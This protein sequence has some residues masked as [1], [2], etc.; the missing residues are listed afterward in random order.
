MFVPVVPP[1]LGLLIGCELPVLMTAGGEIPGL[2]I[3]AGLLT[4]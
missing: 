4:A 3:A 1:A 2:A